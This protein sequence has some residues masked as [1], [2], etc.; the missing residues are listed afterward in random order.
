MQK[1]HKTLITIV[2]IDDLVPNVNAPPVGS[3][4]SFRCLLRGT[5]MSP[6]NIP[7]FASSHDAQLSQQRALEGHARRKW[8]LLILVCCFLLLS[9]A[10]VTTSNFGGTPVDNFSLIFSGTPV[11]RFPV[12]LTDIPVPASQPCLH[13][14]RFPACLVVAVGPSPPVS[15]FP[16]LEGTLPI[17][18]IQLQF[19]AH[20][21]H[22]GVCGPGA[23]QRILLSFSRIHTPSPIR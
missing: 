21:L 1:L 8:L 6:V 18:H 22:P 16:Y 4:H 2:I 10:N 19:P 20:Q 3:Q 14:G 23:T 5:E 17:C 7:G 11:G 13:H 15:A 12:S 9:A